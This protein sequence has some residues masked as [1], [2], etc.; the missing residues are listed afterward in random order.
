MQKLRPYFSN[1]RTVIAITLSLAYLV[2]LKERVIDQDHAA[3][4]IDVY[5]M[6]TLMSLEQ[7]KG[8][9]VVEEDFCNW[10]IVRDVSSLIKYVSRAAAV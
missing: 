3:G 10:I 1:S 5:S 8:T 6:N 4:W 7:Y 9:P 2:I